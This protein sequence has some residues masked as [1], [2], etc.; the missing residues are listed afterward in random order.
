LSLI[1]TDETEYKT[2]KMITLNPEYS[3][4]V[5]PLSDLEYETLKNSIKED[6]LHYHI[7]I[8]SKGEIL[9]G[10]HRYKICKDLDI[11]IKYEIKNFDNLIEEKRFVIDINLKRRQLNDFKKA[12]L[13]YKLEALYKEQARLR[14][15][16]KLKNVKD[17]LPT[18][19]LGSNDR[20]DNDND[21]SITKE[22]VKGRT[23]EVVSKKNDL[24]PK[25]YQRART[26]IENGS[27]EIKEKLRNN[28][29]TI[30]K[31]YD[32]IRRD[33]KREE[34][35]SQMNSNNGNNK[36]EIN[37]V[38]LICNDFSK[39]D[40]ETIPDNSIDLIF[41]DP[42]YGKEY[43][44][45]YEEVA[46]LA[47]RVLK[48]G[49]SLVFLVGHIILDQVIKI[50][51]EFSLN[52]HNNSKNLQYW[53]I[54]TVKH[55]GHH[56]KVYPRHVFAEWK[57]LLWYVKSEKPNDL[58]ISNTIGDYI[59]SAPQSKIEHE[60]QQSTI[61]AEYIIKNL[62]LENQTVLDPMMGTGTTGITALNLN[63]KFIG[64]EIDPETFGIA[65]ANINS[66]NI[67][68]GAVK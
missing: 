8:N 1:D 63:R 26:I 64:I 59:E 57:P 61:E 20:N 6:G 5:Y 47:V 62:T 36:T 14:Q 68:K 9:D 43:L 35:I 37:N 27:E 2:I 7:I 4:L 42:P 10:H 54:L 55:S 34:L 53:W 17:K 33:Q 67:L 19:S 56:Q 31:E 39:I 23:S 45:L 50:F 49:G 21:N 16:S 22:E 66:K 44:S 18:S 51:D 11:P 30:S 48:P 12:E 28:K 38:K 41:T 58:V 3:S 52:K 24:S 46:K 32:K 40:S 60:W 25:T 13:A 29:T 65:K 15:L